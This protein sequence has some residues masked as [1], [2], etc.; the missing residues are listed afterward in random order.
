MSLTVVMAGIRPVRWERV[1]VTFLRKKK[2]TENIWCGH[3]STQ[4]LR[5]VGGGGGS[6]AILPAHTA[7]EDRALL[8]WTDADLRAPCPCLSTVFIVSLHTL[9]C[10]QQG[11]P[12]V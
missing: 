5:K 8:R 1:R 4:L 3:A 7:L 9:H 11:D 2:K 10:L 12:G 6:G